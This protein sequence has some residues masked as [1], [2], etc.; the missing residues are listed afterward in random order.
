MANE[1]VLDYYH[2]VLRYRQFYFAFH[3]GAPFFRFLSKVFNM[4]SLAG[5]AFYRSLMRIGLLIFLVTGNSSLLFGQESRFIEVTGT[6]ELTKTPNRVKIRV[7]LAGGGETATE[8][9]R[10]F[11]DKRESFADAINAMNFPDIEVEYQG[12]VFE[13]GDV[14]EGMDEDDLFAE[15]DANA[16]PY[17]CLEEVIVILPV[18]EETNDMLKQVAT[19]LDACK[20]AKAKLNFSTEEMMY[21]YSNFKS[22]MEVDHS[23]IAA[24]NKQALALAFDD[25]KTK[26]TELAELSGV[27]LGRVLQISG[28]DGGPANATAAWLQIMYSDESTEQPTLIRVKRQL[29]VRF[30]I[31]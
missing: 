5:L 24:L 14:N 6:S 11:K 20:D 7:T 31:E 29:V 3:F 9:T 16:K 23:E 26:A 21:G 28:L 10:F 17:R 8:A 19:L 12:A 2:V 18:S 1:C 30:E 27:K 4:F 15:G 25:A 13:V 22:L